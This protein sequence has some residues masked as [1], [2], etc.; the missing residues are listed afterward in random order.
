MQETALGLLPNPFDKQGVKFAVTCIGETL[1]TASGGAKRGAIYEDLINFAADVDFEKCGRCPRLDVSR[2]Y[3]PH[4]RR[5]AVPRLAPQLPRR[6]RYR[7]A[8]DDPVVRTLVR[9]EVE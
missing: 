9:E 4:R 2:E 6:Q 3:F 1:G 8:P 7:G 5:R